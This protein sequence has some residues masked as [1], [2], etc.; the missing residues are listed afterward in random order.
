[1][2]S[3]TA[4]SDREVPPGAD[5]RV[6]LYGVAWSGFEAQLALRGDASGPR[7]AYLDGALELMSPSRDHERIKSYL[8]RLIEA[9]ALERGIDLSPYGSWTLRS[10][11][12]ASGVEPDECY[13]IGGDQRAERPDLAIEV[14][15]T[16]GGLDK[17]EIYRRLEVAEVWVWRDGEISIHALRG[18]GYERVEYSTKLEGIDVRLLASF[19]DHPTVIQAVRAFRAA[20]RG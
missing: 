10:A 19:L 12:K 4:H 5:H 20:L 11:P 8:G 7:I 13:I 9:Y 14:D 15:W 3:S 6:I 16:S 2:S 1:M 18:G 17:L